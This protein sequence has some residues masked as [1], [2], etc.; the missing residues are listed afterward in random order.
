MC[1]EKVFERGG[2]EREG[3]K[4]E[5]NE[6]EEMRRMMRMRRSKR[7]RMRYRGGTEEVRRRGAL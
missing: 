5:E 3:A 1:L 4:G 2:G 6:E 7:R